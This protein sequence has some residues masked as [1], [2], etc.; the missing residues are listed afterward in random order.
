MHANMRE[1]V[2]GSSPC[3]QACSP[4][5]QSGPDTVS[6]MEIAR[7]GILLPFLGREAA[8]DGGVLGRVES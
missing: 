4:A 1:A 8:G 7:A 6:P 3:V 5:P 2:A